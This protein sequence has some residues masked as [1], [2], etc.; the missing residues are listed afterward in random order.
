MQTVY[1]TRLH[2]GGMLKCRRFTIRV[3]RT[4]GH[5]DGGCGRTRHPHL[6]VSGRLEVGPPVSAPP[7]SNGGRRMGPKPGSEA[8]DGRPLLHVQALGAHGGV[9]QYREQ[10]A[11]DRR[12]W[13]RIQQLAG[14]RDV[15]VS[16]FLFWVELWSRH[17]SSVCVPPGTTYPP[18]PPPPLPPPTHLPTHTTSSHL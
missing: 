4:P 1:H 8:A 15:A 18:P 9:G 17:P 16:I 11:A 3:C 13:P 14:Q 5:R 10:A 12:S 6:S 2:I 7:Y